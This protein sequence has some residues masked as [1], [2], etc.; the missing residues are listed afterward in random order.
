MRW[1]PADAPARVS[2]QIDYQS[3]HVWDLL[4]EDCVHMIGEIDADLAGKQ[5]DLHSAESVSQD[6]IFAAVTLSGS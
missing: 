5:T 2:A 3:L 1:E 6:S 4:P